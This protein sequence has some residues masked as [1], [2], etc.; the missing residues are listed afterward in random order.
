MRIT[1]GEETWDFGDGTP[2]VV[3]QSDGNV[4]QFAKD[5]YAQTVHPITH[6]GLYLA[7]VQGTDRHGFIATDRL[8]VVAGK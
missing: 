7:H 5:G 4:V 3:V 6:A 2:S 8:K 1:A